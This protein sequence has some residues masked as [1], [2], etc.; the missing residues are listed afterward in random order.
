MR[1]VKEAGKSRWLVVFEAVLSV[2]WLVAM[3]LA[4]FFLP[5]FLASFPVFEIKEVYVY[6]LRSV[7]ASAVSLG[8]YQASKNNWLFLNDKRLLAKVN[9]LVSNSVE[10][11]KV[12]RVFSLDGVRVSVYVKEREPIA[13]VVHDGRVLM[14]DGNGELFYNSAA[15]RELPTI[16]TFSLDHIKAHY[17]NL[18]SLLRA[19]GEIQEVYVAKDRTTIY[20]EGGKVSL[21]PL[22][23]LS[24]P[25]LDRLKR[26]YSITGEKQVEIYMASEGIAVVKEKE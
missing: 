25:V 26:L 16:Y 22:S 15:E 1:A 2:V 6:G 8:V 13:Y 4:G 14:L 5:G 20:A 12:E 10:N 9:E 23:K 19:V 11:V 17:T 21:P 3:G 18:I 7:P 24:P